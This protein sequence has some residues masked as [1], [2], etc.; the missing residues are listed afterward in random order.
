MRKVLLAGSYDPITNGHMSLIR[1]CSEL[2]D[3]VHVVA[4]INAEK[5]ALFSVADREK[6]LRAACAPFANAVTGFYPGYVVEYAARNG[7]RILVRGVRTAE[8]FDYE[9]IMARNNHG[10]DPNI[11]TFLLPADPSLA[12]ICSSDVRAQALRGEDISAFVPEG[13]APLIAQCLAPKK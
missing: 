3:E 13:V 11:T 1:T 12:E 2:F 7:I 6:M 8:D 10:F 5:Q 4:F 9:M